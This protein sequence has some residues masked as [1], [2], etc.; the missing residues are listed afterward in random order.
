MKPVIVGHASSNFNGYQAQPSQSSFQYVLI[1]LLGVA[2]GAALIY[3]AVRLSNGGDGN[4]TGTVMRRS[5]ATYVIG[6]TTYKGAMVAYN[7]L[8]ASLPTGAML[9][10]QFTGTEIYKGAPVPSTWSV[11]K[12]M[13]GTCSAVELGSTPPF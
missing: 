7:N 6:D 9:T 10:L 13:D 12:G 1:A 8:C 4:R 11:H 5:P 2:V 3:F